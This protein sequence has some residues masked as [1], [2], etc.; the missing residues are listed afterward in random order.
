[1]SAIM[2]DHQQLQALV[3]GYRSTGSTWPISRRQTAGGLPAFRCLYAARPKAKRVEFRPP[4][5]AA[6]PESGV[7]PADGGFLDGSAARSSRERAVDKEHDDL[8]PKRR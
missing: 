7:A 1:M 8:S 3:P 4:D 5:P 2:P 6:I